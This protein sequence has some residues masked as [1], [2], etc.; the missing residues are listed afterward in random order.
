MINH[1]KYFIFASIYDLNYRQIL[2]S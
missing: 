1:Q 2:V